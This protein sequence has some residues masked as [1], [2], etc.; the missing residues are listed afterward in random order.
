MCRRFDQCFLA[1][2][3]NFLEPG[4]GGVVL[5]WGLAVRCAGIGGITLVIAG[6][7]TGGVVLVALEVGFMKPSIEVNG[8][9]ELF[10]LFCIYVGLL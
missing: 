6:R 7:A 4:T 9:L 2:G 3:A 1:G 8:C 10:R 5:G